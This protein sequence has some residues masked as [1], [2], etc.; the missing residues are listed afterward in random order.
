MTIYGLGFAAVSFSFAVLCIH[1]Y[2][3]RKKLDL[4][5]L[6]VFDTKATMWE[7]FGVGSVG[8]LSILIV[9][10]GGPGKSALAGV[11]YALIGVVKGVHGYLHGK[12]RAQMEKDFL[13]KHAA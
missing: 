11:S 4:N 12:K 8:L 5:E 3:Q 1:A 13:A 7:Y 2:F 10:I 9:W 6:E